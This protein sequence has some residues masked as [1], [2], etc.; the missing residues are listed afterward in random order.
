MLYNHIVASSSSNLSDTLCSFSV[1]P[2]EGLSEV[3]K[4]G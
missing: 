3:H 1:I 2:D 4:L